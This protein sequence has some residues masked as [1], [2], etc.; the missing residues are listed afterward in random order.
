MRKR[1]HIMAVAGVLVAVAVLIFGAAPAAADQFH[2]RYCEP[3]EVGTGE[4][5]LEQSVAYN[6]AETASGNYITQTQ[7]RSRDT[8]TVTFD[9]ISCESETAYESHVTEVRTPDGVLQTYHSRQQGTSYNKCTYP[10][11]VTSG[12]TCTWD[13]D[14]QVA[15]GETK[16]DE[17]NF[18]CTPIT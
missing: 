14:V 3:V 11:G 15:H 10:G 17:Q 9:G 1:L 5:C 2:D 13:I 7:A 18:T 6:A 16:R 8:L 4:H 12:E